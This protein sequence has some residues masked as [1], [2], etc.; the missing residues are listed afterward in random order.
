MQ[1][2]LKYSDEAQLADEDGRRVLA[3]VVT[4]LF[5][6]WKLDTEV[7]MQLLGMSPK[8]RKLLPRYRNGEQAL[9]GSRD[10]LDRA[11]Y[12]LGIHKGLRLLFPEDEELRFSWVHRRNLALEGATPLEVMVRDGLIGIARV[13]RLVDFQRG[14]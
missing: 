11:G 13:A 7:Q 1:P 3:R 6:R 12:L 9:P 2:V 10:N 5:D 14:R 4:A 8:S